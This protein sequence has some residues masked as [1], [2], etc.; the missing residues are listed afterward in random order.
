MERR[1]RSIPGFIL[2]CLAGL[3]AYASSLHAASVDQWLCGGPLDYPVR[4]VMEDADDDPSTIDVAA[5]EA[6][7][8]E[9]GVSELRGHVQIQRATQ[10]LEA[11]TVR[12]DEP[13]GLIS[14]HENVE[15]WD[16]GLFVNGDE[17]RMQTETDVTTIR[18]PGFVLS[19]QHARGAAGEVVITGNELMELR[20]TTYTTCNPDDVAWMLHAD[21]IELDRAEE[22]GTARNV[23]VDF[24]SV[25]IFW[26]PWLS[27]SLSNKRKSGFLTP[28]AGLNGETGA[29]LS[30]P[31]YWNIAPNMDA[32]ITPRVMS[33]RGVLLGGEYR[34]LT[35]STEGQLGLEYLPHDLRRGDARG[36]LSFQNETRFTSRLRTDV[37]L[38]WV[39]DNDY[40]EQL[41]T[42]LEIASTRFL[43]RR[44]DVTYSGR[45]WSLLGRLQDYQ[46]V[47]DTIVATS[48]PYQRLPQVLFRTSDTERNRRFNPHLDAEFVNFDRSAGVTGTRIDLLPSLS[49]PLRTASTFFI[50][51]VSLRYTRY[52]LDNTAAG[53]DTSPDRTIPSFSLDSG[54]YLE[55]NLRFAGSD[56]VQTLEPRVFYL[57]V[58]FDNQ[59]DLPVFDTGRLTF[60]FAQL[61]REDR[62]SGAD[63][64]GDA[65]QV[66]L[67]LTSRIL[68][69]RTGDE[70]F[71]AS[72]GQIRYLSDRDVTLPGGTPE[73]SDSSALVGELA[74]NVA[75]GWRVVGGMQ[76]DPAESQTDKSTVSL[77]Y[78]PEPGK[79]LNLSYRFV[80]DAVEQTDASLRWPVDENWSVV[81]RWN[82]AL[83]AHR[84][85][86]AFG[87][88][89]YNTCC[90]AMRAVARRYL[91]DVNADANTGIFLQLELKGLAG[92]G[93]GTGAFLERSIPG[94]RNRF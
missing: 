3:G 29:E 53:A 7:L 94:Y 24:M 41:G 76:W 81:G 25:P 26:S 15:F 85:L 56:Y 69:P 63:R 93:R 28:S 21:E 79:V 68:A 9:G 70:L 43:Q 35:R 32:T 67:A 90:W 78:Q 88:F 34:F 64:V 91:N 22:V 72:V 23:R 66:T 4:P 38:N 45:G 19:Q 13:A 92:V 48:R 17:A 74:A 12:Y 2:A 42:N 1:A 87:G 75:G 89:E 5:D 31:Y 73:T 10:Q 80:R 46:T 83:P 71:R 39:S 54:V 11:S 49:Y 58:P 33:E 62:F 27:F 40:L 59:S 77:R 47:D 20:D 30:I 18:H 8:V 37:D 51:R 52:S 61:F 50:P 16:E 57:L 14:A 36:A 6:D 84:T 82:Y 44:G 60:N 55:R 65:H 86:E